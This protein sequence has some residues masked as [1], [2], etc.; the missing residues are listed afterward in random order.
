VSFARWIRSDMVKIT[1]EAQAYQ[2][3][4]AGNKFGGTLRNGA[5]N[6]YPSVEDSSH[7]RK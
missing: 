5:M 4:R 1:V 2:D 6:N 7:R 3:L